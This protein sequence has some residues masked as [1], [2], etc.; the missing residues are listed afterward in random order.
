MHPRSR[1]V[2]PGR[3]VWGILVVALL[4]LAGFWAGRVTMQPPAVAT[5]LPDAEVLVDVTEQTLGRELNLNVTVSQPRRVLAA[6]ALTGVVTS[7]SD[8]GE[9][10]VGDE[11][12]RVAGVP[13]RAVQGATPFH[14]AL[15]LRDRGEDVRQLQQALVAL[16]LLSAADGTYGASTER[17][18]KTW[19]KQLGIAQSGRVALGE[20]VAVPHLP[21][22]LSL[23]ADVIG[24]GVV[25]AGGEKVVHVI[26]GRQ[27]V[28]AFQPALLAPDRNFIGADGDHVILTA[29]GGDVGGDVLAQD[30]LFQRHPLHLDV[31]VLGAEVVHQALHPDHVAIVHG[32]DGNRRLGHGHTRKRDQSRCTHQGAKRLGHVIL[33]GSAY[34]QIIAV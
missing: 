17:A 24:P 23:D 6:N 9:V 7:V 20:L 32:C 12:Y 33:P 34:E 22:A 21:S 25:L 5:D 30:V 4:V 1:T 8:T 10:A 28:Q 29:A 3:I 11:L 13:V 31:G 19:Q 26:F 2:R 16:G 27:V 15:G 18:V 14:R